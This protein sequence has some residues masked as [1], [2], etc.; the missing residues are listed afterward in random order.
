MKNLSIITFM[1]F[2]PMKHLLKTRCFARIPNPCVGCGLSVHNDEIIWKGADAS[3]IS[4]KTVCTTHSQNPRKGGERDTLT[5]GRKSETAQP[6]SEGGRQKPE[7]R[8]RG[9]QNRQR[10][11]K[12]GRDGEQTTKWAKTDHGSVAEMGASAWG[13]RRTGCATGRVKTPGR[14]WA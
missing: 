5:G 10:A 8:P 11:G 13:R 7:S 9:G 4:Y 1:R 12:R 14:G 2:A 3:G 6:T